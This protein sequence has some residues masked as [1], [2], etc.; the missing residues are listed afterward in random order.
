MFRTAID[1]F[2]P[3]SANRELRLVQMARLASVTGRW[4]YTITLAVYAYRVGGAGGVAVAGIVRLA[5]AALSAFF[6]GALV[7]RVRVERLLALGGLLRTAAL[8]VAGVAVLA[9]AP[10]AAVYLAVAVES[11]ISTTIRPLQN[12]LLPALSRTP[13][14]LTATNLTLSVIESAGV[15]LGP[16][17]GAALLHGTSVGIVFLAAAG[18]YLLSTLLLLPIRTSADAP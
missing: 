15:F 4:A 11:A 18:A 14:Q 17:L 9:G 16:L 8:V 6:A 3:S 12:S 10:P 7:G 13:E 5:P 1:A 2:R